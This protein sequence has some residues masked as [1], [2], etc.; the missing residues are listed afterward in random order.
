MAL[1]SLGKSSDTFG[2]LIDVGSGSVLVAVVHSAANELHPRIVWSYREHAPIKNV[3]SLEQSA[4]AVMSALVNATIELDSKGRQALN[5]YREG[6]HITQLQ[7]SISAPWSYTVTKTIKYD[8]E[9]EFDITSVLI[10][11]LLQATEAKIAEELQENE[12]VNRLG[13]TIITDATMDMLANGYRVLHPEGNTAN[14]FS[15]SRASAVAQQYLVD[16]LQENGEKL[17][18]NVPNHKL[19]F[20]LMMYS[21]V[22]DLL[23]EVYDQCLVDVTYEATEI[24]IVRNGT[25]EYCT[26]TPFGSFS[27]AREICAVT[28]VPLHE[29]FGYLHTDTPFSFLETLNERQRKEVEEIFERYTE[30]L[31]EL[32]HE[33]GDELSIPKRIAVHADLKSEPFFLDLIEKAAKRAIKSSPSITPVSR[34]ILRQTYEPDALTQIAETTTDTALLLSALFFHKHHDSTSFEYR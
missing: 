31:T 8:Q 34:E 2:A 19:S 11:E 27:L 13:L 5:E 28:D 24:G 15:L 9:K 4:K 12:A 16:A 20:I 26:H 30:R 17:F 10:E 14:H 21:V 32:F 3:D 6:A 18:A 1:F 7:V 29:A 23:P 33:T 25:L 22:R